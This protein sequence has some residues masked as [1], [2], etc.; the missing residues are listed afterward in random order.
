MFVCFFHYLFPLVGGGAAAPAGGGGG[1]S[2][3][4]TPTSPH[5]LISG[6]SLHH[7]EEEFE[8]IISPSSLPDN[9]GDNDDDDPTDDENASTLTESGRTGSNLSSS[10]TRQNSIPTAFSTWKSAFFN[11]I[12]AQ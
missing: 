7:D 1:G 4:H 2:G 3:V 5:P 9:D 6:L 8:V 10:R 12:S 11:G